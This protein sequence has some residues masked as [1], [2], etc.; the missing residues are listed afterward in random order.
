MGDRAIV[1]IPDAACALYLHWDGS[2]VAEILLTAAPS[3]RASDPDYAMARLIAAACRQVGPHYGVGVG[4]APEDLEPAT[5]K[6]YSHGDAGVFVVHIEGEKKGTVDC[7]G[8][9]GFGDDEPPTLQF[10]EG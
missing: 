8:G 2:R 3:M 6:S 10:F 5:M 9:Y 7:Y 1:V 4:P